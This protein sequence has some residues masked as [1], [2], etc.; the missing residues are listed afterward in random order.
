MVEKNGPAKAAGENPASDSSFVDVS[1][2]KESTPPRN[3]STADLGSLHASYK[4]GARWFRSQ[5]ALS[6]QADQPDT[7]FYNGM[8]SEPRRRRHSVPDSHNTSDGDDSQS[9]VSPAV[10]FDH[11]RATPDPEGPAAHRHHGVLE[12]GLSSTPV[13]RKAKGRYRSRMEQPGRPSLLR[14]AQV[15]PQLPEQ[16][17][18]RFDHTMEPGVSM[19]VEDDNGELYIVRSPKPG[20]SPLVGT[21]GSQRSMR[22]VQLDHALNRLK[23][24]PNYAQSDTALARAAHGLMINTDAAR[25]RSSENTT[26]MDTS[27]DSF[28]A[29]SSPGAKRP[30]RIEQAQLPVDSIPSPT[31]QLT[32]V[33]T[34]PDT[35]FDTPKASDKAPPPPPKDASPSSSDEPRRSTSGTHTNLTRMPHLPPKSR[36]EEARHLAAF[37]AMMKES[38]L[39]ERKRQEE[40]AANEH[41]SREEEASTRRIWNEEILPCW[42]RAR[43]EQRYRDIWWQGVPQPLRAPLWARACGN[44]LMLPHDLFERASKAAQRALDDGMVPDQLRDAVDADMRQTL[45]SLRLFDHPN[46]PMWQDLHDVLYAH[47]YVRADEACQRTHAEAMDMSMLHPNFALYVPGTASLAAMLLINMPAPRAFLAMMNIIASKSWLHTLYQLER[48][49]GENHNVSQCNQP[50]SVELQGYERVFNTLMAEQLPSVYANLH[51]S[52]VRT[53]DYLR[54]W[55]RT[56]FVPWL[57]VDTV[58]RLWDIILLDETGAVIFRI[59][60]ALIQLLEPRLYEHDR[61]ALL[62]ILHGTNAGAL[63]VWRR[64]TPMEGDTSPPKDRIYAQYC[65]GESALFRVLEEQNEWWRDSTLRRLL[66]RELS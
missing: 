45:P 11:G 44:N 14:L 10:S 62:S 35:N 49:P 16:K 3:A 34:S 9:D 13:G 59:A 66:D 17:G 38:K 46:A 18:V 40:R 19:T 22:D 54:A 65:I 23:Q 4:R 63:H 7:D 6:E 55:I 8:E 29:A 21:G 50:A 58:A 47:V 39:T 52:G 41:K 61:G 37:T 20:L 57:D 36:K 2:D 42:T 56:L 15:E 27:S 48:G 43:Q 25:N 26:S 28:G 32:P 24:R 1:L 33:A 12:P 60:L 5:V 31:E 30:A 53:S 51:K 64:D